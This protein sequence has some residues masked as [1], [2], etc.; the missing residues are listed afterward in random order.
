MKI[1]VNSKDDLRQWAERL[2]VSRTHL[3]AAIAVAGP[4]AVAVEARIRRDRHRPAGES[5]PR[6]DR[7]KLAFHAFD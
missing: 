2:G 6:V 4:D 1:D 7:R 3:M 5:P